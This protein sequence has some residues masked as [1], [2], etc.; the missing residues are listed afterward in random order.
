MSTSTFSTEPTATGSTSAGTKQ[1]V[2]RFIVENF[3]VSETT[4][5]TDDTSLLDEGIVDSTGVLEVT[6]FL[7]EA[8]GVTIDDAEIIP[9]NLDT[10][11]N[12]AGFVRRKRA[13][14]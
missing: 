3:F 13:E 2:R 5:L 14:V 8:F 12:I 11:A 7:E 10:I 6:A 9:A 1:A 4:V